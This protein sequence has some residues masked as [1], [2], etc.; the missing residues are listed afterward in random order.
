[1]LKARFFKKAALRPLSLLWEGVY[2]A[3]RSFYEYGVLKKDYYKVPIISVGNLTF[4][5]T[6]KTPVIIWLAK[7]FEG[8]SL[9]PLILTRG[10][11][12][13]LEYGRGIIKAGQRFLTNPKRFGDEPLMISRKLT[14][15]AVVVGKE[16]SKNLKYYFHEVSPDVVL[17]DDGM[18]HIQLYRSFNMVL[19][20]ATLPL[21]RYRTAPLGYLREGLTALKDADAILI[22]RCDQVEE[23]RLDRLLKLIRPYHRE[24][25]PLVKLR[26][27]P[28]GLYN[29]YDEYVFDMDQLQGRKV[30]AVTA[31]A[32]PDSFYNLLESY[33][34][35]IVEKMTYPDHYFFTSEDFNEILL[36]NTQQGSIIVT[37]E[38]DIVKLKRI[39]QDK[40]I[41]YVLIDVDFI[42]G[43]KELTD[44]LKKV[45]KAEGSRWVQ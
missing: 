45:A 44:E 18:Q 29:C 4:G 25:I 36:K 15:G 10:Y 16:R 35:E 34:A 33:G 12:G 5:G 28:I 41:H 17:L 26:Y 32:S 43:E 23:A 40:S 31:I 1:M 20:D 3:R 22:S 7:Y 27:R 21:D 19:F 30:L 11:K 24:S 2:R 13:E 8:L 39:T 42:S 38:K 6:G 37:S 14:K 9:T